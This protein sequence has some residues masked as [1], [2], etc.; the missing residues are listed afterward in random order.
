MKKNFLFGKA[1]GWVL[2]QYSYTNAEWVKQF[3]NN[4]WDKLSGLSK[5]EALKAIN[6]NK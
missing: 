6:R 1:I 2:R 3:V 4:H 5:R